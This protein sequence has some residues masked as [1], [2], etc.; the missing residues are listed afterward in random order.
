MAG[1][2]SLDISEQYTRLAHL[3]KKKDK[4]EIHSLGY[5]NTIPN[6]FTNL[7]EKSAQEQSKVI[8]LLHNKLNIPST[9]V[10]VVL[11]DDLSYSQL[12]LMPDLPEKELV[13][14]IRL[15]ADEFVPLPIGDV[16]IDLETIAKL[17]NGKLL[18]VFIAAQKKIVDHVHST[19]EMA[20][21]EPAT[22]E[23]ELSAVGRMVTEM[24]TF[25]KTP[26]LIINFG[27]GGTS[28]YVMNPPF[29][30]FQITRTIR[31]GYDII[32][33]DLK[34][35]MNLGDEKAVEALRTIGLSANGS[36]NVNAIIYPIINEFIAEI[37]KTILLT[38]EKYN[39]SISNIYLFNYDNHIGYLH[40]TIQNKVSV[41]TQSLPLSS[42]LVPNTITQ[43]FSNILSSFIPV[44][45]THVR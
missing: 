17:P 8:S 6:F 21:L 30:Y 36:I 45:A 41:P 35:N 19:I 26:T 20:N 15:Q 32:L 42:V 28:L 34:V 13:K 18:I 33:R 1:T 5:D 40:E 12:L 44:I 24:F 9:S 2:F 22:L 3:S 7:V 38:K 29:P 39:V 4:I 43:T 27:Y 37:E 23:N 16:Y 11:P 14:S 25:I 31:I 10:H